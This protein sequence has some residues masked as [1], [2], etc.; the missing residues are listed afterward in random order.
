[1][2]FNL[3]EKE[4]EDCYGTYHPE[5]VEEFIRLIKELPLDRWIREEID[6]LAGDKLV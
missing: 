2:E 4:C 3:S 5:D 6:Q 1:M